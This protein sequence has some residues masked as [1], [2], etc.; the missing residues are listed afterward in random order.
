[1]NNTFTIEQK[2]LLSLLAAMQPI[3]NKRTTLDIT[4]YI[5]FHITPRELVLK[6]TDLEISLRST[7]PL[8]GIDLDGAKFLVSGRRVFELIKEMDGEIEFTVGESQLTLKSRGVDLSLNIRSAEDFPPFPERIENL[9]QL[10]ASFMLSLLGKV[11]FL[12]PQNNSNTALNGMLLELG[13]EEMALVVTD[14]HCLARAQTS[15]YH[16]DKDCTW[17]LPR[18]AVLELKKILESGE[19]QQVFLGTCSGQL[20]FSGPSFNFFT[21]LL[22][23][24]FP[25]YKT[26]MEKDQFRS[27]RLVRSEAVTS[28]RNGPTRSLVGKRQRQTCFAIWRIGSCSRWFPAN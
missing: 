5:L 28:E 15:E 12:I 1:M 14:G 2:T 21:K 19:A 16:L 26:V 7:T 24:P 27:A 20:V 23:D 4:E 9:L 18:R 10:E 25:E 22:A 17:L 8:D 13:K 11:A 6:A 3:C